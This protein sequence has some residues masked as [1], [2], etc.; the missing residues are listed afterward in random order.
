MVV[1]TGQIWIASLPVPRLGA[2]VDH[3][4]QFDQV[5]AVFSQRS[6]APV[7]GRLSGGSW[8]GGIRASLRGAED[9]GKNSGQRRCGELGPSR[10]AWPSV[11]RASAAE[12]LPATGVTGALSPA[13]SIILSISYPSKRMR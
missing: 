7:A 1:Q 10:Q 5:L 3:G 12:P 13:A 11:A 2:S 4:A 6:L 8:R 9:R